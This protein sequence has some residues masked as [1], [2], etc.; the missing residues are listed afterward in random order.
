MS[1]RISVHRLI[2]FGVDSVDILEQTDVHEPFHYH[3][4]SAISGDTY[5]SPPV[6]SVPH[7]R[8]AIKLG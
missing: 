3:S 6:A 7:R 4:D 8:R 2:G 5:S 1:L